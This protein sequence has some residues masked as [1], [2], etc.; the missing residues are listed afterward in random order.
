MFIFNLTNF[1]MAKINGNGSKVIFFIQERGDL[2]FT[3]SLPKWFHSTARIEFRL[4]FCS[5]ESTT[6]SAKVGPKDNFLINL[7]IT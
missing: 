4:W 7:K 5:Y 2:N 6:E 1:E 3:A